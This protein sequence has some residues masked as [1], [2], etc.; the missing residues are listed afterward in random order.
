MY[1]H[2]AYG[3]KGT[4]WHSCSPHT[5]TP[6]HSLSL[7]PL[8]L[9]QCSPLLHKT[10]TFPGTVSKAAAHTLVEGL[11][12]IHALPYQLMVEGSREGIWLLSQ[13]CTPSGPVSVNTL[14]QNEL[15]EKDVQYGLCKS[16]FLAIYES[17]KAN[18]S[19]TGWGMHSLLNISIHTYILHCTVF[20]KYMV[21]MCF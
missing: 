16:C 18:Y 4:P 17:L 21:H 14:R 13:F 1:P 19:Q 5:H 3:F 12:K 11:Q 6:T 9:L 7:L 10:S 15:Q 20:E 2:Y 8:R